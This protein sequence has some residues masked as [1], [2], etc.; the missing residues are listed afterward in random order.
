MKN[1]PR[2]DGRVSLERGAYR[3]PA[4][5]SGLVVGVWWPGNRVIEVRRLEIFYDWGR[6]SSSCI[7][8][9]TGK[10]D[11]ILHLISAAGGLC[12][13][14]AVDSGVTKVPTQVRRETRVEAKYIAEET[15]R[16]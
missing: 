14:V 7:M 6:S 2:Q 5:E 9:I 8:A 12:R 1:T 13:A 4:V 15:T 3:C 11:G 10:R 16:R